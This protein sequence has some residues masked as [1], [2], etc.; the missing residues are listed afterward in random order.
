MSR[1]R[2]LRWVGP[3]AAFAV[4]VAVAGCGGN[5]VA[6]T[7]AG[8]AASPATSIVPPVSLVVGEPTPTP[9]ASAASSSTLATA[10]AG[11]ATANPPGHT[12][13]P[14]EGTVVAWGDDSSG[15]TDVPKDLTRVIGVAAGDEFSL[16]LKSDGTVVG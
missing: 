5:N 15:Q 11:T 4:A 7:P 16:A 13:P 8:Q 10:T 3:S 1:R 9:P 2:A 12:A 6:P 14:V